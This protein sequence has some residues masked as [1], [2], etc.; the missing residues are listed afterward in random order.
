VVPTAVFAATEDFGDVGDNHLASRVDRAA[1]ELVALLSATD[2][3]G[4]A[5]TGQRSGPAGSG[6]AAPDPFDDVTPFEQLLHGG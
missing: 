4:T 2:T 5:A 1:G 3:V 6:P